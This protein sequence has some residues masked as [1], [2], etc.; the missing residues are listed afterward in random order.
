MYNDTITALA[1]P[2][3]R[4]AIAIVRL[5]GPEAYDIALHVTQRSCLEP[6]YAT[7]SKLFDNENELID[8][9]LVI[10]FKAPKSFT[11]E[12]TVEF[13]LHG[14]DMVAMRLFDTLIARGARPAEAGEFTRRAF[15][16]D[17]LDL[18]KAE[19]IARLIDAQSK[20][21]A[22][23]LA[24]Q[25]T[26]ELKVFV[27]THRNELVRILAHSEVMIDYADEALPDTLITTLKSDL[28]T[29]EKTLQA[30]LENS[31]SR[32]GFFSGYKAAIIGKPNAGKSSLLN[33]L[34]R[35]ERAIVSDIEG[36]TRDRIEEQLH[37]GSHTLKMIDTAGIRNADDTIEAIGIEHSKKS[38]EEADIIIALFDASRP[39]DHND[40]EIL[41]LIQTHHALKPVLVVFNKNDLKFALDTTF[42]AHFNSLSLSCKG[43]IS[44]LKEALITTLDA[45]GGSEEQI[46]VSKR[47][48]DATQ[49]T[50]SA[51]EASIPPLERGE[52]EFFSFHINEA[53]ASI[54]SI[55][56][57][58]AY[59]D[60]LDEMFSN[61]CLG[62]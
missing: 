32:D 55:S 7:L 35:Y 49:R 16:N 34:L 15:L 39:L 24:R 60:M 46:L 42:F 3:G 48:I 43:D 56:K 54:A 58:Y 47:Q 41:N 9:A 8:E 13:Q 59:D 27:E 28:A 61:F 14:G 18:T 5:S 29:L 44:A 50:I 22:K 33:A 1:T 45:F 10:Y 53:I 37:L 21:S 36:T 23:L 6:R 11:G 31:R 38:I 19:A 52:L 12:P 2:R 20:E 17:K 25:L 62:K 30:T 40:H 57:P 51:I 26:G 4:G